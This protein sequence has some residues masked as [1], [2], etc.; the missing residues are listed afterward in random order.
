MV[1][2]VLPDLAA[3][4]INTI[5]PS[6]RSLTIP[7]AKLLPQPTRNTRHLP[8][9]TISYILPGSPH[10]VFY[11]LF[12]INYYY[13]YQL[14]HA[15]ILYGKVIFHFD[16]NILSKLKRITLTL[17]CSIFLSLF[18]S[19]I[20]LRI[21]RQRLLSSGQLRQNLGSAVMD[22]GLKKMEKI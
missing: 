12:L 2:D 11:R 21:L 4:F 8:C 6:Q 18:W 5:F 1:Q 7:P 17:Q 3:I 19:S 22:L 10:P 16:W 9:F 20:F 13:Y 14:S 15:V